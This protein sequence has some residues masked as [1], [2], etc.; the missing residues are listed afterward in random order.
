MRMKDFKQKLKYAVFIPK[1]VTRR[2]SNSGSVIS[3][4]FPVRN[5]A[6]WQTFFELLN[7]PALL[8]GGYSSESSHEVLFIFFD[9]NGTEVGR[10]SIPAPNDARHTQELGD[11][12]FP[13]IEKAATFSV[14]HSGYFLEDDLDG[15]FLAERGYVGYQRLGLPI[16]GYVH[17]NLDSIAFH[18]GKLQL[19]GN[20]GF[21]RRSYQ[22]QHPMTGEA[23]Y[24]FILTNP[25]DSK[26][27]VRVELKSEK[28]LWRKHLTFTLNPR[29]SRVFSL[30]VADREVK[31][32]RIVSRLY[33]GRP[34]IFRNTLQSMDVFHG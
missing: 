19:L 2:P 4:L 25:S 20:A 34:V 3:D 17:G 14:F 32:V 15:S 16:R 21:L 1:K 33:L 31:F 28:T 26:V 29:G 9:Q 12:F 24:E 13:E 22:V 7:I 8:N 10:K 23:E 18:E 5:D 11:R 30:N 27:K 6:R